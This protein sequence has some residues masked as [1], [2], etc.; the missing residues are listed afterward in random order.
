M[1]GYGSQG[2]ATALN[3]RD[4]GYKVILGLKTRSRS[5]LK[6]RKEGFHEIYTAGEAAQRADCLCF[7]LPDHL[8]GK[9]FKAELAKNLTPGK[10][11]LFLHGF[12]VHFGYVTPPQ[13]CDVIMIAPHGPG[14]M[15]REKYLTNR[16]MSAF[17]AIHQNYSG[18]AR[19]MVFELARSLGFEKSRLVRSTFADEAIGDTFGEQ[20]VLCGGL[21]ELILNGYEVLLEKGLPPENAYLEVAYQLDLI[22]DLIKKYGVQGMYDRI[23]V[24]ARVGSAISGKEIVDQS[25]KKRMRRLYD[26]IKSGRFARKLARLKPED[27]S[28]IR[29]LTK[30]RIPASFEKSAKKYS[31]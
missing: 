15:V 20:A 31:K 7:A 14:I 28:R 9:I 11:L 12:S 21:P 10:T 2:R 22:I 30:T 26:D 1:L 16:S 23:S 13:E 5:R 3:L 8:H 17:W 27:I 29:R 25:V 18:K 4:S 24:T 19:R 6:A